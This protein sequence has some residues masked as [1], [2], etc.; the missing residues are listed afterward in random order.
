MTKPGHSKPDVLA[1]LIDDI[2]DTEMVFLVDGTEP[3]GDEYSV[4]GAAT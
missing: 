4:S 3:S 2:R 1:L